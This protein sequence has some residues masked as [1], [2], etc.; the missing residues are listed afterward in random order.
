MDT[1]HDGKL[2]KNEQVSIFG[3]E[4]KQSMNLRDFIN[5]ILR[6][7]YM[8]NEGNISLNP[9]P[10]NSGRYTPS[11][12][13]KNNLNNIFSETKFADNINNHN[14]ALDS[15][16]Y[17][18]SKDIKIPKILINFD[19]H[20]DIYIGNDSSIDSKQGAN[21]ANWV[22]EC[23]ADYDLTDVYWIIPEK[24]VNDKELKHIINGKFQ[25]K[26]DKIN[27]SRPLIQNLELDN[28]KDL[29]EGEFMQTFI[30]D[31]KDGKLIHPNLSEIE[32]NEML[33]GKN[34]ILVEYTA[35][36]NTVLKSFNNKKTVYQEKLEDGRDR[37]ARVNIHFTTENTLA[38]FK[39]KE[40]MTTIDMDYFSNSGID[41][42][43]YYRDNKNEEELKY[44]IF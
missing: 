10:Q 39:N 16:E 38:D 18:K 33:F 27:D 30:V 7:G 26:S 14:Q 22:N 1:N 2:N 32:M 40:V 11:I 28:I 17:A 8:D 4:L 42:T 19:S 25:L 20:S 6:R 9:S 31:R 23:I 24:M 3:V 12:E 13:D 43:S 21:I 15:I 5:T 37:F 34:E 44:S 29:N 36:K 41:T 35:N